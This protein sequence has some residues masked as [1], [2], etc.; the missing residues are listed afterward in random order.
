MSATPA[1]PP[2]NLLTKDD[3]YRRLE[4]VID[5]VRGRG[6]LSSFF[7]FLP[8]T[9]QR[10]DD[11]A[12]ECIDLQQEILEAPDSPANLLAAKK[13][14]IAFEIR[15]QRL[16][17]R[18]GLMP[19]V[20]L[21]YFGLF[22]VWWGL[23]LVDWSTFVHKTLGVEA[24]ERLISLGIAGAFLYLATFL[25]KDIEQKGSTDK[26]FARVVD[27]TLR[28]SLAVIVPIVLVVL[29]FNPDGTLHKLTITPELASFACGYSAK[30]VMDGLS[31]LVEKGSKM[32]EAI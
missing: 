24:P 16:A 19:S 28:V 17:A 11:L 5:L 13:K 22:G 32:I 15:H 21:L 12:M 7:S 27:L 8:T 1:G 4:A 31:K 29:F 23:R 30:L 6:G 3:L 25:L 2:L 26:Q 18:L 9:A 14:V 20:T 10:F